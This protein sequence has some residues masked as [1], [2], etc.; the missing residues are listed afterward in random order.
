M[1]RC[2]VLTLLFL[3]WLVAFRVADGSERRWPDERQIGLLTVHADFSVDDLMPILTDAVDLRNDVCG[4]L[5]LENQQTAIHLYLFRRKATFERYVRR[6]YPEVPSRRALFVKERGH[7]MVFAYKSPELAVDLRH[8]MTHAILNSALPVVPLWLDEGLAE[9]FEVQPNRRRAG[10]QH[11]KSIDA[12]TKL[13]SLEQLE[14][15]DGLAAMKKKD[16]RDAWAWV[17]WMLLGSAEARTELTNYLS[18][19]Q[20]HQVQQP[21][22]QR[23]RRTTS[24]P[25]EQVHRHILS[26]RF[27]IQRS[28]SRR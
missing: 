11:L 25:R 4:V 8:E 22:S 10:N 27:A 14:D 3:Q 20:A 15:I 21:L 17:H 7:A 23:I 9:Y 2:T 19:L 13:S 26:T 16:Y 1:K 12:R 5:R 6:Y 18:G 28:S 24:N